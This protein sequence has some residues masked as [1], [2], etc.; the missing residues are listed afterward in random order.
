[1]SNVTVAAISMEDGE[2]IF[3]Q[4][5]KDPTHFKVSFPPTKH[6]YGKHHFKVDPF[7]GWSI[8]LNTDETAPRSEFCGRRLSKQLF[9]IVQ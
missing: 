5:K 9:S 6:F 4:A 8:L 2:Y 7:K 3:R 1:V